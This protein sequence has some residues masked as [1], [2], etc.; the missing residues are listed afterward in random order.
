VDQGVI[1]ETSFPAWPSAPTALYEDLSEIRSL[2]RW[3][4]FSAI[5]AIAI[6]L[7]LVCDALLHGSTAHIPEVIVVTFGFFLLWFLAFSQRRSY[8]V[9]ANAIRYLAPIVMYPVLYGMVHEMIAGGRPS[10]T[11]LID[12][13]LLNID[14]AIFG[15]NPII[16]LGEHQHPMMTDVLH[17]AYFSYYFGA[18]VLLI[19]MFRGNAITDFRRVLAAI[20]I[21]WYGALVS[22]ALFPALG[23]QRWMPAELPTLEGWLPT[24]QWVQTFLEVNLVPAVRDCVPSM[25]TGVTLLT[26]FYARRYQKRFFWIFLFPGIGVIIGT[27]Y[28]QQHY[29]TDVLLGALAA[30]VIFAVVEKFRP[31]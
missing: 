17:L 13:V 9:T 25:H 1:V 26:L 31:A 7:L 21:G 28:T 11:H 5:F 8:P 12:D 18:P 19:L 16:W 3:S 30:I 23:P 6:I 14:H 27:V 29:V 22:Y 10:D 15:L 4:T 2:R 20:T 24:T